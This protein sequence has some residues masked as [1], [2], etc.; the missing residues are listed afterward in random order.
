MG[1]ITGSAAS[2]AQVADFEL[3]PF[4]RPTQCKFNWFRTEARAGFTEKSSSPVVHDLGPRLPYLRDKNIDRL[5]LKRL[6]RCAGAP[7]SHRRIARTPALG[8]RWKCFRAP[9]RFRASSPAA[10]YRPRS[11]QY[12]LSMTSTITCVRRSTMQMSL[13]TTR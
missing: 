11:R 2:S 10:W 6:P 4:I 8:N 9:A 7:R 12:P 5:S 1:I 3:V 13:S